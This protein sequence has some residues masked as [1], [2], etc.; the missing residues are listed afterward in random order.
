MGFVKQGRNTYGKPNDDDCPKC[1]KQNMGQI[2][3]R[4]SASRQPEKGTEDD[5][6]RE[7]YSDIPH[8]ELLL[9]R[10]LELQARLRYC[11]S[12]EIVNLL[13]GSV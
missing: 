5:E 4:I 8:G 3:C 7:S 1:R 9:G 10:C 12:V 2:V 11:E 13:C 6:T